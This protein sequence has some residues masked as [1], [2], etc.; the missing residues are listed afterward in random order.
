MVELWVKHGQTQV[1]QEI[2][3]S[4]SHSDLQLLSTHLPRSPGGSI[5]QQPSAS[6]APTSLVWRW[7]A[8]PELQLQPFSTSLRILSDHEISMG[9]MYPPHSLTLKMAHG[10]FRVDTFEEKLAADPLSGSK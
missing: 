10:F 2:H 7:E 9:H 3:A 1:S 4:D 6:G 5:P 8:V